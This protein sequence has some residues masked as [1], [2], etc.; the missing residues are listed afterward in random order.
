MMKITKKSALHLIEMY[1]NIYAQDRCE[2]VHVQDA[3]TGCIALEVNVSHRVAKIFIDYTRDIYVWV[4]LPW[5]GAFIINDGVLLVSAEG[6]K[7]YSI[8]AMEVVE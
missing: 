8:F 5:D 6:I 7:T 2:F 3:D 4:R 1:N